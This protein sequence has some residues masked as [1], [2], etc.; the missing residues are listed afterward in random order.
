MP[1]GPYGPLRTSSGASASVGDTCAL[2][3]PMERLLGLDRGRDPG[4]GT[5]IERL[6]REQGSLFRVN[7]GQQSR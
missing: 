1:V 2:D 7:L 6:D 3:R 4:T 5:G